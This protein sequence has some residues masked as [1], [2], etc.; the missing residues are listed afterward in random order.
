ML[1]DALVYGF[2]LFVLARS[3]RW[4]AGAALAKGGRC[5]SLAP[6]LSPFRGGAERTTRGGAM[7]KQR[8]LV[9]DGRNLTLLFS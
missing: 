9:G 4:Q 3:L 5:G 8:P 1:G 6:Y 2:S 7:P